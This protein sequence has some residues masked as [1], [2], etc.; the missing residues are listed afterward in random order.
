M[1]F[2]APAI[3]AWSE[4]LVQRG[5]AL[6]DSS[7]ALMV[8]ANYPGAE[9]QKFLLAH[10]LGQTFRDSLTITGVVEGRGRSL[11][12]AWAPDFQA[13]V[14]EDISDMALGHLNKGLLR[15]H[16]L[17]EG[18][19]AMRGEG[20]HDRMWF[21]VRDLL[22]EKHAWPDPAIPESLSRLETGRLMPAIPKEH[23]DWIL[24]LTNILM[25]EVRAE[26]FFSFCTS[27]IR[28]P[29]NFRDRRESALHA[30]DLVDRIRQ[31]EAPHVGYLTAV[32]SELRSLTFRS[33]DGANL[34]GA[35]LIDPVW[36][37]MVQW[38][39]IA[40]ADHARQKSRDGI[41]SA[42]RRRPDGHELERGFLALDE[43]EAA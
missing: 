41:L 34:P 32:V 38:H 42:L 1:L 40:N 29:D 25:I 21:A 7:Q 33:L 39:A 19:D 43:R 26:K 24:L 18:G 10:G 16:G 15:A 20:G 4:A 23:E 11:A 30:A 13:I 14:V 28:D 12:D 2:R 5:H 17:D 36:R 22:F 31:D 27:V 9:Q 37:G 8:R 35:V 3:Q 6:L